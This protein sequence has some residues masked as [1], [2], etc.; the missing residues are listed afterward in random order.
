MHSHVHGID[1]LQESGVPPPLSR[2][3][4]RDTVLVCACFVHVGDPGILNT[5]P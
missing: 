2:A 1:A 4:Q 3:W 5:L